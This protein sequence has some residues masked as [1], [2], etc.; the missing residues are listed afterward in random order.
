MDVLTSADFEIP[1]RKPKVLF[2]DLENSPSLGFVWN[3]WQT[4]VIEFRSEWYLLSFSVKWQ[5]GK[6]ITKC[7]A[8]YDGY[9]A[10]NE[11]DK[12]LVQELWTYLDEADILIAH[13]GDKFDLKKAYTRFVEH[14]LNP[15]APAKTVDTLKV[16]RR[17]FSFNSNKLDDLGRRLGVGRKLKHSGFELWRRCME[18][19][20]KAWNTMKRYNAQDV[21][22]LE[23]V[24][25]KMLPYIPAHPHMGIL[26]RKETA[27]RNCASQNLQ[28]RGFQITSVGKA[29]RLQC[30]DC[31][32]WMSET[33]K[34]VTNVR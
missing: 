1:T 6:Q 19:D 28:R 33:P 26:S 4:N 8:D 11:D 17:K 9:F 23:A 13:N 12:A 25:D 27:C 5:G 20:I 14:G 10:G 7:L 30:Q 24:Y 2:W 31:G 34:K 16:A 22:L 3:K 15:P 29:Q 18:G 32:T 21:R